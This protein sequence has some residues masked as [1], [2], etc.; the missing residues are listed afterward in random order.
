VTRRE[1]APP[2]PVRRVGYVVSLFPSY[3]ET[4]ILREI[5]ALSDRGVSLSIFSLRR[6]KQALVQEDARAFVPATRYASYLLSTDVLTALARALLRQTAL[7]LEIAVLIVNGCWRRPL[8]LLKSL[9]FLPKAIR[10]AEIARE[11]GL[12][13]LHAHWATYPATAALVMSRLTGIPW[14]LTCHAHDIFNDPS[15]LP[16]KIAEADFVL[17]CTADNKRYLEGLSPLASRKVKVVYHGLDL[18]RFHP[19]PGRV[20]SGAIRVLA[21]GSLFACKG[22]DLLITALGLLR[23]RGLDVEATLAGGGPEERSLRLQVEKE[24]IVDRVR[25]P[26]YLT[27][28]DLIPLYQDAD[29]FVLPAVLEQHWG[30]PNVLVEALACGVPVVTTPLPSLPELV[31]DGV[32]G[33]VA[34]NQD[35][36]DLA[37]RIERLARDPELRR[38]LAEAG[39]RRVG[40]RFDI[41][42]NIL[43]VT[44]ALGASG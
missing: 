38:R 9:A 34:R 27:Q 43:E 6:R 24:G 10:F 12:E 22:F 13:R 40:E 3:D 18:A 2:S 31:E 44:R 1:G 36:G 8:A 19:R 32:H 16:E 20:P 39:R 30:I 26:G 5:K 11:E 37:E 15:L 35:P 42:A 41:E 17:T 23:R 21:V 14:G 28:E 25:F 29:I 7:V 4:F 33:L